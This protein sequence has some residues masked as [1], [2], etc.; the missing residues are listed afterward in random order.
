MPQPTKGA[1]LGGS[2]AHQ[3]LILAN[4]ATSLFRHGKIRTTEAKARKLRPYAERLV[5]FAKRGDLASRRRTI[6]LLTDKEVAH[7]L[8]EEIAPR[9]RNRN[10]GYTRIVKIGPRKGDNAPMA[11]VERVEELQV[12]E[13]EPKRKRAA[14]KAAKKEEAVAALAGETDEEK[15][16]VADSKADTAESDTA[17]D[18]KAEADEAQAE[19]KADEDKADDKGDSDSK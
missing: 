9:Y 5:T 19:D 17:E 16:A 15:P 2:P 4:L 11:V 12:A 7:A 3:R 18:A 1:R 13:Q 14:T 10:G 6:S 8:F